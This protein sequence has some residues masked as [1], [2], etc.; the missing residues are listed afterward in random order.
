MHLNLE[1]ATDKLAHGSS[2]A[3]MHLQYPHPSQAQIYAA[4]ADYYER[5]AEF[6]VEML[7]QAERARAWAD[8]AKV[9]GDLNQR[10]RG[11]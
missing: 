11:A 10:V 4:L 2:P 1:V 3:E 5:Q 7:R 8:A 6:E 9:S